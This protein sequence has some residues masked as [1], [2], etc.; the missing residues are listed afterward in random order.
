MRVKTGFTRRRRHKKVL[1]RASGY[2]GA[3]SRSYKVAVEKN[4]RALAYA[5]RDRKAKKRELRSLW[6]IRI[7]AAAR[8]N[9]VTY[10][11][12]MGALRASPINLDRKSLADLAANDPKAFS[13]MVQSVLTQKTH[14]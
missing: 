12:L 10:S 7:S 3:N 4:D 8:L 1:K 14:T 13:L 5:Y 6:I 11:K 2:Y 9:D